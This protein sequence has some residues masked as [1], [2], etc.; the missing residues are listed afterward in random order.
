MN[1]T[2]EKS[3]ERAK[4]LIES[5]PYM[6]EFRHKTIVIKYGGHAMV[7]EALK[8]QFALDVIL[9]K[10]IGINPIIVHGG[11]P[12]INNLLDRLDIKPS[13]VQ[14]MRVTDGET[15]DVVEMVL[16]GKVNKEIVGL[17][18]HCGGKAVGL[19]GRD[20]D[21]VCAEQLQ[22][23]QAQVGDNPPELID[24]GRVG[25][26]TK[27]NSHVLET[28]SQ[29]D[30]IPI[31]APVGVGEDG[32]AFNINADLVASAIAAELSAEKLILLTDVPGVKNKAGDLLTTLE[33]QELNG[34]IEDGTIMGGMIPK[35]RCCEDA[36]KGGVAKT[37]IVDGRVEHAIL[38]EIFTRDGVGTEIY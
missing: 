38:L 34:L 20:G 11:G 33:W 26:V 1:D 25:Q 10:Q 32:R 8:K 19:S 7:D 31:I 21:L 4:V 30:F 12:Q 23:N 35:V 3:I 16:V 6:Q 28:L 15:M 17:I 9:L 24:V 14:G 2:V 36:V 22:M 27:I 5:L 37:Y 18:N 13:Y 29:D